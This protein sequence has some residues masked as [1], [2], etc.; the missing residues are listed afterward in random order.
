MLVILTANLRKIIMDLMIKI[1]VFA[2][3]GNFLQQFASNQKTPENQHLNELFY[4]KMEQLILRQKSLN[5]WFTENNVRKA[6][7]E[8]SLMLSEK[9]LTDW[10]KNYPMATSS[11]RIGVIMAGN[12]PAVGFHDFL[13]VL[14]ANHV[15]VGKCSSSDNTLIKKIAEILTHLHPEFKEKII[16]TEQFNKNTPADAFIATGSNNSARYFDYYFGKFPS[17][18]RKNRNSVAIINGKETKE[19]FE[20]LGNDIFSY[21]G[22]GCR[23]V[24]KLYVPQNY[25]FT[26]FFEGIFPYGA[27]AENNKYANNYD[28][29]KA[30]YLLN[31]EA[32]LD[33]NFVL[34][35]EDTSLTSP[36][37][38][39][40]YEKYTN[41]EQLTKELQQKQD[42][43]QCV[44]SQTTLSLP[45]I[46]FGKAQ[47]P[48]LT[49]YADG[50][51]TMAFLTQL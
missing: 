15:F 34:L 7:G 17:I 20:Q 26:S 38:V 23:N 13:C 39:L 10:V 4:D 19:D 40:F 1:N 28:Y 27:V 46:N 14:L 5:G 18:I 6:L 12:I 2:Q 3:L 51:D 50:V 11:K 29:H 42:E 41:L 44:V 21:F 37:G 16:F 24:S 48:K 36:V 25:D 8:I 43:I 31:S 32:L 30:I 22:L 47:S 49:D 9:A 35:K 45:T 33:N